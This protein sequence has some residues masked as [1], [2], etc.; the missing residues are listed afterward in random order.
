MQPTYIPVSTLFGA[1]TRHTVPL[2]QRPYVWNKEDQWEPLWE[3]ISG[4]LERLE[5][6]KNE[7]SVAS[8]FLGTIVLDQA[9]NPTG[10]LPRREV[11][12]GQQRL[13]TLQI[14]LKAAEH[15]MRSQ[16]AVC[17]A[18]SE[19]GEGEQA[20]AE[21]QE[22]F[23]KALSV[24]YRQIA[25]LTENPAYSEDVERYKVWPTNED[26]QQFRAV[27]D[28]SF[29]QEGLDS[30]CR[31]VAAYEYFRQQFE[32]YLSASGEALRAQRFAAALKDYLK[33]IVL[34][35]DPSDEPQAIFE[36]LNAHGTPLL[37]ADLMKN[38]L[39]WE[40]ARQQAPADEFYTKYWKPFDSDHDYW[41]ER[42]GTGHAA[43]ARVDTFLQNWLTVQIVEAVP[44]KHLY[45][46]FLRYTRRQSDR[47]A[48]H[49]ID[50]QALMSGIRHYADLYERIDKP[51]GSGRFDKFLQRLKVMDVVVYHPLL[52]LVMDRV[53]TDE[54][55]LGS[56]AEI[57]ETFLVRRMVCGYQTRGYNTLSLRLLA[58]IKDCGDYRLIPE[59]FRTEL[60]EKQGSDSWACPSDKEFREQWTT[61][62]FYGGLRRDRVLM[63]L[64]AIE[65]DYQRAATLAE[66]IV[67]FDWD[68]LQVEHIMP[69]KWAEHWE[70]PSHVSAEDRDYIVHGIGNLTLISGKL[71]PSLSNASW[72]PTENSSKG[73][74]DGLAEHS[75]LHLNKRLLTSAG[76]VWN[77]EKIRERADALCDSAARIWSV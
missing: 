67:A 57:L 25:M 71:N 36:T 2:F 52:L 56:A 61:R 74:R 68:K 48:D 4:L 65:E 38:W 15:A 17:G 11:I 72:L 40:A 50:L 51:S 7:E 26:R 28:A 47:S 58:A 30:D 9:S 14:V 18:H 55:I 21:D 75:L 54:K 3:D 27:M 73:K 12:D 1:Q 44:A 22:S 10:S 49:E 35:L 63:I 46:R 29:D 8:H 31:M 23:V 70:L 62:R 59:I 19:D 34:D 53:G 66:P 41:R 45:D 37:P 13:T 39:L 43:R 60:I 6:R 69:R 77:E 42:V 20:E 5:A 64:Q 33:V 76:D 24:A 32:A 16:E